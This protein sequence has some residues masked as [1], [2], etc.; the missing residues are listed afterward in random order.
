MYQ[1]LHLKRKL[2]VPDIFSASI[3]RGLVVSSLAVH[4]LTVIMYPALTGP[5]TVQG[6]SMLS[7]CG[8][9]AE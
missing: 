5:R 4:G 1:K 6:S 8:S 2:D 9:T 7:Q 3:D